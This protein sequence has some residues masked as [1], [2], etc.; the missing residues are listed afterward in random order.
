MMLK[1]RSFLSAALI[2]LC[3][4]S[5][6]HAQTVVAGRGNFQIDADLCRFFGDEQQTFVEVYYGIHENSLTYT[7]GAG[8][9]KGAVRMRLTV[10]SESASVVNKEWIVPHE[11]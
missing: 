6:L 9:F 11:I 8:S 2:S 10:R 7:G 4:V 1:I 5:S 3:F